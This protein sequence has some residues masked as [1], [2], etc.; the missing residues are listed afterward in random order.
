VTAQTAFQEQFPDIS[1]GG[2][3]LWRH[4]IVDIKS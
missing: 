4:F 3:L 1:D 2:M